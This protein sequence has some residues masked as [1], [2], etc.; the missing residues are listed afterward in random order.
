MNQVTPNPDLSVNPNDGTQDV[1]TEQMPTVTESGLPENDDGVDYRQKFI[2]STRGA[3]QLFEEKKQ[4]LLEKEEYERNAALAAGNTQTFIP[5]SPDNSSLYPGFEELDPAEQKR[6]LD[7]TQNV[8]RMAK[9]E[10]YKDPALAFAQR[11]YNESRWDQAFADTVLEFPELVA[12]RDTFKA[13]Y[14]HP[15]NV[16]DNIGTLLKD[17]AKLHLFDKAREVGVREAKEVMERVQFE[18]P[19]GGDKQPSAVR[20]LEDWQRLARENPAKFAKMKDEYEADLRSGKL[21][22]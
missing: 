20:S 16:P 17:M 15:T 14:F 6:L 1:G 22:E 18:D 21:Q 3:Q 4:W 12:E 8:T 11:Q 9:E 13:T 2:D 10:I 5:S 19:T 7:Y